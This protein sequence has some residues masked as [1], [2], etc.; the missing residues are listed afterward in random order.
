MNKCCWK[1]GAHR[2]AP[3]RVAL[4]L[5]LCKTLYLQSNIKCSQMRHA[6]IA[7]L[8]L[9]FPSVFI[10]QLLA[11]WLWPQ[12]GLPQCPSVLPFLYSYSIF[13][14]FEA[15]LIVHLACVCVCVCVCVCA[16]IMCTHTNAYTELGTHTE[17]GNM[18][19][20]PECSWE[21]LKDLGMPN[22]RHASSTAWKHQP[23]YT[24][25]NSKNELFVFKWFFGNSSRNP[26]SCCLSRS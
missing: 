5:H 8:F 3:P 22:S 9:P 19:V 2:P 25:Q 18:C 26:F 13:F 16:R 17:L 24:K 20:C 1:N 12:W 14:S 15:F 6:C 21:Q 11:Q 23:E 4:N 7:C 10:L